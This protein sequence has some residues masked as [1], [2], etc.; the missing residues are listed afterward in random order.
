MIALLIFFI[1]ILVAASATALRLTV[2]Y[3]RINAWDRVYPF[4]GLPLWLVLTEMI[5]IGAIPTL[6]NFL[7]ENFC[8]AAV[9][10]A[11]PWLILLVYSTKN[12]MAGII[13]KVLT[14]LPAAVTISLRLLIDS[15]PE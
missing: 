14:L 2:N 6:S 7:A 15:L 5:K 12:R 11:T 13:A 4:T 9:S 3:K 8:I 10:I 1:F